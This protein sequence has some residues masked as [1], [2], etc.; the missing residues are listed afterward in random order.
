VHYRRNCC[1]CERPRVQ[2]HSGTGRPRLLDVSHTS[3]LMKKQLAKRAALEQARSRIILYGQRAPV[4]RLQKSALELSEIWRMNLHCLRGRYVRICLHK[5]IYR[6]PVIWD[7]RG[8]GDRQTKV[9]LPG[10]LSVV[11][12]I[13]IL[14]CSTETTRK[15]LLVTRRIKPEGDR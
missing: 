11:T 2:Q 5:V 15:R 14:R 10:M 3:R 8:R 4:C 12:L 6:T 9:F 1:C 7:L 13:L